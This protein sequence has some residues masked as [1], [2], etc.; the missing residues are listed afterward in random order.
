VGDRV[1]YERVDNRSVVASVYHHFMR[2]HDRAGNNKRSRAHK[3]IYIAIIALFTLSLFGDF[4]FDDYKWLHQQIMTGNA[5]YIPAR[6]IASHIL[7]GCY[8]IG[9]LDPFVYKLMSLLIHLFAI[10]ALL[11]VAEHFKR[12]K[13]AIWLFAIHPIFVS[14][15]AYPIQASVMLATGFCA[16]SFL[17][18]DKRQFIR[19]LIFLGLACASKQNAWLF[20]AVMFM[21]E[22]GIKQKLPKWPVIL[23]GLLTV[24]HFVFRQDWLSNYGCRPYSPLD[25][26]CTQISIMPKYASMVLLPHISKYTISHQIVL[27]G[28]WWLSGM[29]VW[30]AGLLSL[31][32]H[33]KAFWGML[34]V[35]VMLI[36]E[37]TIT[38]LEMMFEHRLYL[39]LAMIVPFVPRIKPRFYAYIAVISA[40][41]IIVNLQYQHIWADQERLWRHTV[42]IYPESVRANYN[43]AKLVIK[44]DPLEALY[45]M[46]KIKTNLDNHH[47]RCYKEFSMLY[48]V[49]YK[50]DLENGYKSFKDWAE[51]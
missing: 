31:V 19:S 16:L 10:D 6:P 43:L 38:N 33:P 18:W 9:G 17:H 22:W 14:T 46:N 32:R 47:W 7:R 15:V 1:P 3:M 28:V 20:P 35:T 23:A 41:L 27:H 12:G 50:Q 34:C 21:Y 25:R 45:R 42:R 37:F 30:G 5:P 49:F 39:P 13:W 51:K 26:I 24:E 44:K 29:I 8:H 36:P 2:V 40:W 48:R 11:R 4:Q